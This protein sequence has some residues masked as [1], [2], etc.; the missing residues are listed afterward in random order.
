VVDLIVMALTLPLVG[1]IIDQAQRGPKPSDVGALVFIIT[2]RQVLIE[3]SKLLIGG[4][5]A[6]TLILWILASIVITTISIA[7]VQLAIR[8]KEAKT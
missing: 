2:L 4:G 1:R 6:L 8:E 7:L 3:L 5:N